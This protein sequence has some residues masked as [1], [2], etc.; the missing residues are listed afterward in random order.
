[1]E[2][3]VCISTYQRLDLLRK[4]LTDLG[5]QETGGLFSFSITVADNDAKESARQ[6]VARAMAEC[7]V[8]LSYCVEPRRSIAHVRN[9][10]IEVSHGELIAFIDDDEFPEPD[11][12]LNLYRALRAHDCA[13]VLGP[14]RPIYMVGTPEW[15]V[16]GGFFDRPEHATGFEMPWQEC[17]TGNVLMKR[18]LVSGSREPFRIEFGTGGS[19]VDFFRRMT[20]AGH[21]FIWCDNAVVS[22]YVPP[23]RWKRSVLLKR[24]LLRGR[25][26][27]RHPRGRWMGVAKAVVAIPFYTL[28]LPFLQFR[29]HHLFMRYFV[30]L[31]DHIGRLFAAIGIDL[32]KRREM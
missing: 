18:E 14:V 8:P 13:G 6:T 2:I 25:N 16:K 29:G 5:R 10:T 9:K 31:G 7:P 28:A 24:A 17:R 30:K 19:D 20:E 22:E 32:V 11:W 15:V 27:F 26:S 21:R 1:M 23:N 3:S 12:L 4:L